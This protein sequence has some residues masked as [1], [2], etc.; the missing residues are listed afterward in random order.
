MALKQV[1][2]ERLNTATTKKIG[3][4]KNL[5]INGAMQVAQRGTSSTVEGYGSVDR[6][7]LSHGNVDE[8]PTHSQ[9]NVASGTT[10]YTLGFRKAYRI[11]NG[12]QTSGAGAD[13]HVI[14]QYRPEDQDFAT[15]GW[16]YTSASSYVTMSF[17]CKSSIAQNFYFDW[18]SDNG[19]QYRYVMET[20]SLSADTWTKITKTIPG[21]SNIVLN[22]DT[23]VG[24]Y[25]QWHLFDGTNRTGTRP[26]DAWAALD[27]TTRT[28][29]QTSTWYTTNDSTFEITGLQIEVGS[30]A[31]DFEHRSFG[32]ELALCQRY[33]FAIPYGSSSNNTQFISSIDAFAVSTSEIRA[34]V[35]FPVPMRSNASYTGSSTNI[36]Y[37]SSNNSDHFNASGLAD[38]LSITGENA[39]GMSLRKTSAAS[40]D[41]GTSGHFI[42]RATGG[43]L[44]FSAEL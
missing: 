14:F 44:Q 28:P 24:F 12:N 20:G 31:T 3:I 37:N 22:N 7:R 38:Y 25:I 15:S 43:F 9:V 33:F 27:N 6:M 30:V 29:D 4:N 26:L 42:F 32:Q 21:N 18:Q 19:S 34:Q 23:G 41:A 16:N 1:G 13:D 40:I 36:E 11:T 5:I 17:W 10:P 2:L 35:H 39:Y 8:N